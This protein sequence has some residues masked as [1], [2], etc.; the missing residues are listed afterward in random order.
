METQSKQPPW[1]NRIICAALATSGCLIAAVGCCA[2]VYVY[3]FAAMISP[4][5]VGWDRWTLVLRKMLLTP[6]VVAIVFGV[7]AFGVGVAMVTVSLRMALGINALSAR[8]IV[9][10]GALATVILC[11]TALL[12]ISM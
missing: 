5:I 9:F 12:V 3:A 6:S 8:K 4:R 10:V 2:I 7:V 1:T 11:L